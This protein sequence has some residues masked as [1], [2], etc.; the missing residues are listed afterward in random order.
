M[1]VMNNEKTVMTGDAPM[2]Q[3]DGRRARESQPAAAVVVVRDLLLGAPRSDATVRQLS[4]TK[5][6][7][8][9]FATE[10]AAAC[11]RGGLQ[12]GSSIAIVQLRTGKKAVS[13]Q[14]QAAICKGSSHGSDVRKGK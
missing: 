13:V 7:P 14:R 10:A 5:L 4:P 8:P 3:D 6:P 9:L 1:N 12:L 2:V 11:A